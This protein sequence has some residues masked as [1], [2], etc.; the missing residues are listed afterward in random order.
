MKGTVMLIQ[1][2][3]IHVPDMWKGSSKFII[4]RTCIVCY[5]LTLKFCSQAEIVKESDKKYA[6]FSENDKFH[7]WISAEV[8]IMGMRDFHSTYTSN[9]Q[10]P[11]IS[12]STNCMT[13]PLNKHN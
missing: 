6:K 9:T 1:T 4:L 3:V 11:F 5:Y 8:Q 10:E 7:R 13:M 12:S 2:L